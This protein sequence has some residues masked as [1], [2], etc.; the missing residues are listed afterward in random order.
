MLQPQSSKYLLGFYVIE[1]QKVGH[2][3][4]LEEKWYVVWI[5]F[6]KLK[7]ARGIFNTQTLIQVNHRSLLL[8]K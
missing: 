4:E 2:N 3:Y 8:C 5:F 1:Q 6:T 7:S